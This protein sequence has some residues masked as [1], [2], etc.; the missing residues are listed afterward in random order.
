MERQNNF[1]TRPDSINNILRAIA[2]CTHI[3][4]S[5]NPSL[6]RNSIIILARKFKEKVR[7]LVVLWKGRRMLVVN[8]RGATWWRHWRLTVTTDA[9][10]AAVRCEGARQHGGARRR[11]KS[12]VLRGKSLIFSW[13]IGLIW[14]YV[15]FD[16]FVWFGWMNL[17]LYWFNLVK[18]RKRYCNVWRRRCVFFFNYV[19]GKRFP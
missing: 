18:Q 11:P 9:G 3:I 14:K 17:S 19:Y 5:C 7:V 2:S 13:N 4:A 6:F 8:D 1:K 10:G 15:L 12:N 16:K